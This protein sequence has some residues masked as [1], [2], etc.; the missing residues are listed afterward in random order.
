MNKIN[1]QKFALSFAL[2]T[3]GLSVVWSVLLTM[4]LGE[5]FLNF[6]L[7]LHMINI[8]Y[9]LGI[10][11]FKTILALIVTWGI[12]GYL[13]AWIGAF[14]WNGLSTERDL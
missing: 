8:Q 7:W 1:N 11:E 14:I 4:G 5:S 10:I 3:V 9:T 2:F 13:V 6:V 12:V